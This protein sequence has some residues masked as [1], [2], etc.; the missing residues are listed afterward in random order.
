MKVGINQP[1]RKQNNRS[2]LGN[3]LLPS[4]RHW[5]PRETDA[6]QR[7]HR[8]VDPEKASLCVEAP[9]KWCKA[10]AQKKQGHA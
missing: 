2:L 1:V 7:V 8:Q 5:A 3:A 4:L 10:W 6:Y 9:S